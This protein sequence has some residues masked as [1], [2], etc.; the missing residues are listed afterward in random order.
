MIN[1]K[2]HGEYSEVVFDSSDNLYTHYFQYDNNGAKVIKGYIQKYSPTGKLLGELITYDYAEED[3]YSGR[4]SGM[5]IFDNI[6]RYCYMQDDGSITIME[7]NIEENASFFS[8]GG[9]VIAPENLMFCDAFPNGKGGYIA[10]TN[11][12][13]LYDISDIDHIN[14]IYTADFQNLNWKIFFVNTVIQL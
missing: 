11:S 1:A 9:S 10:L 8:E 5:Q 14:C 13:E 2:E 7:M 4:I 12:A 6:L 3:Y